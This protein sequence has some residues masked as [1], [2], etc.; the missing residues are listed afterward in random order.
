MTVTIRLF[1]V[2][3]QRVGAPEI[4]VDLPEPATVGDLRRA[5]GEQYPELALL[6]PAMMV[7]VENEYVGD[8][9]AVAEGSE[10]ALIP[11]VSGGSA[12]FATP[13]AG[14]Q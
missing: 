6:L 5:A 9:V 1:A 10:I 11:P 3:R 4:R 13:P 12:A 14:T 2:A 8:A 7:A